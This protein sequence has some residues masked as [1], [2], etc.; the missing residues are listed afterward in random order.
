MDG[1]QLL[2]GKVK[3]SPS[4]NTKRPPTCKPKG[5]AMVD[6]HTQPLGLESLFLIAFL[7]YFDLL[8]LIHNS[9]WQSALGKGASKFKVQF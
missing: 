9:N 7:I 4:I 3:L 6:Q 2:L 1:T 8:E 5:N